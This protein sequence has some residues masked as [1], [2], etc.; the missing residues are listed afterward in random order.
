MKFLHA[1]DEWDSKKRHADKKWHGFSLR[2]TRDRRH[3]E[4]PQQSKPGGLP[5]ARPMLFSSMTVTLHIPDE[6]SD[7]LKTGFANPE[8]AAM[9]ALAA[10]AY[11]GGVL[12]LAQVRA[13]LGL[14][15]RW[16]AQAV[17]SRHQVWPGMNEDDFES[18]LETL[19]NM[20]ATS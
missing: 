19:K 18:D 6:V 17:L 10:Q 13:M 3:D 2:V 4:Q 9:E 8:Q 1:V 15:S 11:H 14:E 16:E 7:D 20:T 12:S 5:S